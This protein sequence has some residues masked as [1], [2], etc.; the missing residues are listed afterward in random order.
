MSK[1]NNSRG[2]RSIGIRKVVPNQINFNQAIS[3]SLALTQITTPSSVPDGLGQIYF[4]SDGKLYFKSDK[5]EE[6]DLLA[7]SNGLSFLFTTAVLT[8]ESDAT[9]GDTDDDGGDSQ[10]IF[11]TVHRQ[12]SMLL[13]QAFLRLQQ[14]VMILHIQ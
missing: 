10:Q 9:Y 7:G 2:L 8:I 5:F 12:R 3:G 1:K 14:L 11:Q 13:Y 4:K 6:T